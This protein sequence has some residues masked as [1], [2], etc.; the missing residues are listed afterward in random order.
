MQS[1]LEPKPALGQPCSFLAT[2][3]AQPLGKFILAD[4]SGRQALNYRV[5]VLGRCLERHTIQPEEQPHGNKSGT[6]VIFC[7]GMITRQTE[8][9]ATVEISNGVFIQAPV[10]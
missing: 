4:L 1:L 9:G 8:P 6:L 7:K 2:L 5:L 10:T 3:S